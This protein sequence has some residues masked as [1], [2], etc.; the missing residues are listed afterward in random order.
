M[1]NPNSHLQPQK[2]LV[3]FYL[4]TTAIAWAGWIPYAAQQAFNLS[5]GIPGWIAMMAQYSPTVAALI[6]TSTDGGV[7]GLARFLKLSLNPRVGL[8]WYAVALLTAPAMGAA[9]VGLRALLGTPPPGLPSLQSW[10]AHVVADLASLPVNFL[11]RWASMGALQ[12]TLVY[13]G[14][15]IANGGI[16]EEAGWR[17]YAFPRLYRGRTALTASL[18]LGA[19][20]GAW[21]TGPDFWVGIFKAEWSVIIIPIGYTLGTL[22]LSVPIC[23]V[24]LNA[25][26]SLLPAILFHASYNGTFF[27][28]ISLWTPER[29]VVSIPEW[30]AATYVAALLAIVIG[31]HTL[32][33]RG[34]IDEDGLEASPA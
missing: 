5:W 31:R 17:G 27:F 9:L 16:S 24:F 13:I 25:K 34:L 3:S 11:K 18:L 15:A 30:I 2:R 7:G 12:A 33:R 10:H 20:W 21:H 26:R 29:P 4:L 28:L 19:L 8:P 6:L 22:A 1:T 32:F 14:L 23:W